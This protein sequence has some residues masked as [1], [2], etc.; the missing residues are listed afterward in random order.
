MEHVLRQMWLGA[1]NWLVEF[2]PQLAKACVVFAIGWY[3]ALV[4]KRAIVRAGPR[5]KWDATIAEYLGKTVRYI[6]VG[7]FVV[8]ALKTIGFP[9]T[10]L[11]AAAGISGVI[12]GLG[13]RA[14]IANYFAGVMMLAVARV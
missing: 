5:L 13:V 6:V 10:S 2:L 3:A 1:L 9:V 8:S 7:I 14:Q 12:I 11:L 4:A